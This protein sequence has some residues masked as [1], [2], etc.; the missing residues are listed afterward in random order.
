MKQIIRSTTF[1][2]IIAAL[3]WSTAFA[4]IKIGLQYQSPLQFAALR[5]FL[6]G[7]MVALAFA[8]WKFLVK[9]TLR[10]WRFILTI[11]VIQ[12][13]VQYG[14]FYTGMN[15]VPGALG[16]MI[17]GS[18]PL[19]VALVAHFIHPNDK[20]TPVKSISILTGV[21]GIA[22]ITA[23]RQQIE[24]KN[25]HEWLGI[26]LLIFNNLASGYSNV[27]VSK[28]ARPL[29][30]IILTSSSLMIGG[31]ML[32][33]IALPIEG[34]DTG[35]FPWPY[36]LSLIWLAFLSASA[37]SIWY[38]LLRRPGVMVSRLNVWKF[39]IPVSGAALSWILVE[40]EHPDFTSLAGML[41]IVAALLLNSLRPRRKE[42]P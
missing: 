3:L 23:G 6:A 10:E 13:I 4:G 9:E 25:P 17:V 16:A 42:H 33:S 39:L 30:P 32:Y 14:L 21:A 37:F 29:S 8:R 5:F 1:L 41:V 34:P 27:L 20:L 35:P 22:I 12:V 2:A 15:L 31:A 18:S 24:L 36:Y 11:A 28:S 26:I 40:G 7:L 19:F 38:S